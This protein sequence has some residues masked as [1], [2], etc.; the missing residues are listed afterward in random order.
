FSG[1]N[2]FLFAFTL[3]ASSSLLFLSASMSMNSLFQKSFLKNF[4][5][6]TSC[7]FGA[8]KVISADPINQT[9]FKKNLSSTARDSQP[10][11]PPGNTMPV[12]DCTVQKLPSGCTT[13]AQSG[14]IIFFY[15]FQVFAPT[16]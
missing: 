3:S 10:N 9:F 1:I 13:T 5:I 2:A 4:V 12:L 16:A 8:A 7:S 14:Q 6:I 15:L 11:N